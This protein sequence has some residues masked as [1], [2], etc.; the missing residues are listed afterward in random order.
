[1]SKYCFKVISFYKFKRIVFN[2]TKINI[3]VADCWKCE[4]VV[5]T[6]CELHGTLLPCTEHVT[7]RGTKNPDKFPTPSFVEIRVS[8]IPGAGMGVFATKFIKPG[9]IIGKWYW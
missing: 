1:M 5:T 6:A 3:D 8:G 2:E 7:S 4:A 9:Q